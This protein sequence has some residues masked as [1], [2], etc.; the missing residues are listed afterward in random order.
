MFIPHRFP[1][2]IRVDVRLRLFG[3]PD[4][5]P[6]VLLTPIRQIFEALPCDLAPR[7][8]WWHTRC[9][10]EKLVVLTPQGSPVLDAVAA[11]DAGTE[12]TWLGHAG[13]L[14]L[15]TVG[16][17]VEALGARVAGTAER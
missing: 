2:G 12:V 14:K 9:D 5:P 10:R 16:S 3:V 11:L 7:R 8:G 13:A 4:S 15:H 1:E 6:V 17:I